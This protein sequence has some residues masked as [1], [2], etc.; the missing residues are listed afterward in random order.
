MTRILVTGGTGFLAGW[1]IRQ[2]LE[3]GYEVR[4]TIRNAQKAETIREMFHQEGVDT[5]QLTF[6][7]ADLTNPD[8]W[9]QAM[10]GVDYLIH[11]ASPLSGHRHSDPELINIA[12]EG[13]SN[14]LRAAIRAKVKK[15]VM[16]SSE[17]ANYPDKKDSRP[18]IDETFWTD[19]DNR[20]LTNYQKSKIIAEQTA[21]QLINQQSFTKLTTILPGAIIGPFMAGRRSSTDQIFEMIFKNSPCPKAIYPIVDVRDLAQLHLLAMENPQA[22]NQR[23]IAETKE[24]TMP[25][26]AQ[27]LKVKYPKR[28]IKSITIPNFLVSFLATFQDQMKIIN[29][30]VG[31]HYHRDHTKAINLLHW[32]PRPLETTLLDTANYLIDYQII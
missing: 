16:T 29:T 10:D 18:N 4:T 27:F 14:V 8:G 13:V 2:A 20:W 21:W 7:V 6:A 5:Q 30:M 26:I 28:K 22:D 25:E 3:Q 9:D 17:A 31:L 12:K 19:L 24:I 23:F 11:A 15:V 32:A 1:I